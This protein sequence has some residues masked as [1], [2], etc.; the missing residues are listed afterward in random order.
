MQDGAT[1]DA[2]VPLTPAGARVSML[3]LYPLKF[4]PCL[5]SLPAR[6][7]VSETLQ[8]GVQGTTLTSTH[9]SP[10]CDHIYQA[11]MMIF[12]ISLPLR[13]PRR[14][15]KHVYLRSF[16]SLLIPVTCTPVLYLL[17]H[18]LVESTSSFSWHKFSVWATHDAILNAALYSCHLVN[19]RSMHRSSFDDFSSYSAVAL[20]L[21]PA[22][23]C[24]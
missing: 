1:P 3:W 24:R 7:A 11:S 22:T 9:Q 2:T 20:S 15:V 14:I 4:F 5:Y 13:S 23:R 8:E 18:D 10:L 19:Q 17:V 16:S 21:L 12:I 6:R